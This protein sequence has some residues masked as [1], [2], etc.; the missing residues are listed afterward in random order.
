MIES[1]FLGID[2]T[3][4]ILKVLPDLE[5]LAD[6]WK[7]KVDKGE[8]LEVL[9][10]YQNHEGDLHKA[11]AYYRNIMTTTGR[12][13]RVDPRMDPNDKSLLM[14]MAD[15]AEKSLAYLLLKYRIP[16][17]ELDL[18][19]GK[20]NFGKYLKRPV[21]DFQEQYSKGSA[22]RTTYEILFTISGAGADLNKDGFVADEQESSQMPCQTLQKIEELWRGATDGRCGWYSQEGHYADDKDCKELDPS[23]STLYASIF[24]HYTDHAI[25]RIKQCGIQPR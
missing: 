12:L 10:Y 5:K 21:T 9:N 1:V 20:Q 6:D 16:Q 13:L 15:R 14:S 8:K 3:T 11:F 4:I 19:P 18:K 2:D 25:N 24:G 17:L 23:R 7:L 22:L